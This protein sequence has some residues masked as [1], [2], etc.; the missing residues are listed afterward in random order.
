VQ[1][2]SG[3]LG[4]TGTISGSVTIGTATV[5]NRA[6]LSPG[7]RD[8]RP[9]SLTSLGRLT[10]NSDGFFNLGLARN[11]VV[12]EVV[13]NGVVINAG[14]SFTFSNNRGIAVPAGTVL[15]LINNTSATPI[16]GTFQNLPDGTV[17][18]DHGNTFQVNYEG[19]DGNDLTL[20]SLP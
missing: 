11:L 13:A 2:A 18:I 4:G 12:G 3:T 5:G 17:F 8:T 9:G 15:T 6:V 10:F 1:V 19:G 7:Q 14:A 20:T 16:A